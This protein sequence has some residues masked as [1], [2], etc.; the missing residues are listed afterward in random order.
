MCV[1]I[2][3]A[4]FNYFLAI[5]QIIFILPVLAILAGDGLSTIMGANPRAAL[6]AFVP[7][8]L[9]FLGYDFHWLTKPREDW[10]LAARTI[11]ATKTGRHAC[12]IYAPAGSISIYEF[13][14]PDLGREVCQP[15][16]I[17][18]STVVLTISP[19]ATGPELRK[20]K[21]LVRGKDVLGTETAGMSTIQILR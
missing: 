12:T 20:A 7:V 18:N 5:R 6:Y 16:E 8:V 13:Y 15:G 17:S 4:S 21:D 10:G 19:Y 14:K 9:V 2:A 1:L 11:E 3:D